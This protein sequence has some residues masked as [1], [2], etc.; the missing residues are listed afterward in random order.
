[1]DQS[2]I[3]NKTSTEQK[4]QKEIIMQKEQSLTLSPNLSYQTHLN[5]MPS[6][7]SNKFSGRIKGKK[8]SQYYNSIQMKKYGSQAKLDL[9]DKY[10]SQRININQRNK[11]SQKL[12]Q[13]LKIKQFAQKIIQKINIARFT[14]KDQLNF[15]SDKTTYFHSQN[16]QNQNYY[17]DYHQDDKKHFKFQVY[18]KNYFEIFKNSSFIQSLFN[19]INAIPVISPSG[20]FKFLWDI[21]MIIVI[22]LFIFMIPIEITFYQPLIRLFPYNLLMLCNIALLMD[23]LLQFNF[24]FFDKGQPNM[25]RLQVMIKV[26]ERFN[27]SPLIIQI[28]SLVQLLLLILTVAH[29]IGCIWIQVARYEIQNDTQNI[30]INN[31]N[32]KKSDDWL[33]IYI[34]AYYFST[35]T[36]IT[37]G[38]GDYTPQN[39]KEM[40]ISVFTMLLSCGVFAYSINAIGTIFNT[41]NKKSLDK[42]NNMYTISQYMAKKNINYELQIQIKQYLEYYWDMQYSRDKEQ[43]KHLIDQLSPKLKEQLLLE[44]FKAILLECQIFKDNFSQQFIIDIIQLIEEFSYRPDEIIVSEQIQDDHSLYFIESGQIQ[45]FVDEDA[46]KILKILKKGDFFGDYS[47]FTGQSTNLNYKATEFTQVLKIKRSKIFQLFQ[48]KPQDLEAFCNIK[49]TLLFAQ[50]YSVIHSKCYYCSGYHL[51]TNCYKVFPQFNK[52]RIANISNKQVQQTRS[53]IKNE[54]K[55]N[56][57]P[58]ILYLRQLQALQQQFILDF[59]QDIDI[60]TQKYTYKEDD[61]YELQENEDQDQMNQSAFMIFSQQDLSSLEYENKYQGRQPSIISQISLKKSKLSS[62]NFDEENQQQRVSIKQLKSKTNFMEDSQLQNLQGNTNINQYMTD[63]CNLNQKSKRKKKSILQIQPNLKI[64]CL[65]SPRQNQLNDLQSFENISP[66]NKQ[67]ENFNKQNTLNNYHLKSQGFDSKNSRERN[68]IPA[69][70]S[71]DLQGQTSDLYW[72]V[73]QIIE[74]QNK[75]KENK[76]QNE[77]SNKFDIQKNYETYLPHN[78]LSYIIEYLKFKSRFFKQLKFQYKNVN[79][80]SKFQDDSVMDFKCNSDINQ[81]ENYMNQYPFNNPSCQRNFQILRIFEKKAFQHIFTKKKSKIGNSS[82]IQQIIQ[83]N[84]NVKNQLPNTKLQKLLEQFQFESQNQN[85]TISQSQSNTPRQKSDIIANNQISQFNNLNFRRESEF[86]QKIR[87]SS[88]I[89]DQ[90]QIISSQRKNSFCQIEQKNMQSNLITK[91]LNLNL[92]SSQNNNYLERNDKFQLKYLN[93]PCKNDLILT[94]ITQNEVS[95]IKL[96]DQ[97]EIESHY[98]QKKIKI[99]SSKKIAQKDKYFQSDFHEENTNRINSFN[100]NN[101]QEESKLSKNY[102]EQQNLKLQNL[103][104]AKKTIYG[105]ENKYHLLYN[106]PKSKKYIDA[107]FLN[108]ANQFQDFF[109]L[110][111]DQRQQSIKKSISNQNQINLSFVRRQ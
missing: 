8:Q 68:Y 12:F 32:K 26:E 101:L 29:I 42:K 61:D 51:T 19:N 17:Q 98:S 4:L 74:Y 40:I 105:A 37:V 92:I 83:T 111:G 47:F 72:K 99:N 1:M 34:Q 89:Q 50:N 81:K 100:S 20:N 96:Q 55:F 16:P 84:Q 18:F 78:N 86:Q 82:Q 41:L 75:I 39:P 58:N 64:Q 66:K 44:T 57:Q 85:E 91:D 25:N 38:Y 79:Q 87:K 56:R 76:E 22:L 5:D 46:K 71:D 35:V 107:D 54:R 23:F 102:I 9:I 45:V 24:G 60:Y 2:C 43:E 110:L 21:V 30:W 62:S 31:V 7:I 53:P 90:K 14:Y 95:Q 104:E 77:E 10:N 13:A 80:E 67:N 15:F 93:N 94:Q 28:S 6:N 73:Q 27:L 106:K 11:Y 88:F 48:N 103:Q 70:K 108:N 63:Q 65:I 69:I 33:N 97:D 59:Q 36:M 49:D 3:Q 109:K 52:V